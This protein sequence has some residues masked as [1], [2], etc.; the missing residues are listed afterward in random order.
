MTL[1][2]VYN[3]T[4]PWA[5]DYP[6]DESCATVTA[7]EYRA[8]LQEAAEKGDKYAASR[9]AGLGEGSGAGGDPAGN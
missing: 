3:V 9:L 4:Q 6:Q 5:E 8:E 1:S 7:R 2:E